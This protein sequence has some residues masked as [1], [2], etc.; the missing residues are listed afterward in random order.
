MRSHGRSTLQHEGAQARI[1]E[2]RG[3]GHKS[4]DRVYN[5]PEVIDWMLE[6]R[7]P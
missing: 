5:D 6:Q 1:T 4:W 7:K 2:Y 3:V